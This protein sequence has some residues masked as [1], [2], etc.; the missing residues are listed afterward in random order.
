MYAGHIVDSIVIVLSR[1]DL[2][3]DKVH[4]LVVEYR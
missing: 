1:R 4:D 2:N 3:V